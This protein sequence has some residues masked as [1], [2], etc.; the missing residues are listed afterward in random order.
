MLLLQDHIYEMQGRREGGIWG[1][2][3]PPHPHNNLV[4]PEVGTSELEKYE[5]G[6]FCPE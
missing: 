5:L 6:K 3:P 4:D 1:G 2:A